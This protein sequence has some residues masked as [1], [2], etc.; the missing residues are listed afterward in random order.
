MPQRYGGARHRFHNPDE[1]LVID[2]RLLAHG[3]SVN[4]CRIM[5]PQAAMNLTRV[6]G[7]GISRHCVIPT[8]RVLLTGTNPSA[9]DSTGGDRCEV[10]SKH[11]LKLALAA[12]TLEKFTMSDPY[13]FVV[14]RLRKE[15]VTYTVTIS[16][17]VV[18]GEWCMT[19]GIADVDSDPETR[20][21]IASDLRSAAHCIE[22]AEQ[23]VDTYV[24]R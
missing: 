16:H 11:V 4:T 21:R 3:A 20:R 14:N 15:P 7:D 8:E 13:D 9:K 23:P 2:R 17:I 12:I 19:L 22:S 6:S 24:V 18:N 5:L 1:L 10:S